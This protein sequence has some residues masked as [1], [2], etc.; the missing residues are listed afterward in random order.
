MA[1][2]AVTG[3]YASGWCKK[4]YLVNPIQ[5]QLLTPKLIHAFKSAGVA[6]FKMMPQ[7]KIAYVSI[8]P[9]EPFKAGNI[10]ANLKATKFE[11]QFLKT[12]LNLRE[13]EALLLHMKY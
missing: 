1:Y 9:D 13:C 7:G 2:L 8:P 6:L 11:V 5:S 12:F 3:G 4:F 10:T